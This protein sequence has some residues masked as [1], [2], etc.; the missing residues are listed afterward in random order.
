MTRWSLGVDL[1]TSFSSAA[2]ATA[3]QV[4]SLEVSGERRIPSTIVLDESGALVAGTLAQRMV[5][6]GPER[7]ERNP[8]RYVGRRPMLLGG[9]PVTAQRALA[10]L[11]ELVVGEART[12]FDGSAPASLVLTHPVA[13]SPAQRQ[14]LLEVA[15]VVLPGRPVE[16]VEE[17][18][19]AAVHYSHTHA[20]DGIGGRDSVAVYDLGGGTF[21]TAVLTAEGSGFSVVGSPGGDPE[22]GGETFD[23]RVFHHFGAQLGRLAPEWWE[24]VSSNP[25]RRWQAAAA[26]LLTEARLAKESLS[27]HEDAVQYVPGADTDVRITRAEFDAL[28]GEDVRRTTRL[29]AQSI[30]GSGRDPRDLRGIF[31]TGGASRIPLVRDALRAQYDGLVRTAPDP[32]TVVALGAARWAQRTL[33]ARPVTAPRR[34]GASALPVLATDVLDAQAANGAIYTWGVG[35]GGHQ[36]R[37][38]DRGGR[39]ERELPM[40]LV[41]GWAI[42]DDLVLVAERR[43]QVVRVHAL[44][45][46]LIIRSTTDLVTAHDPWLLAQG[47]HGWVFLRGPSTGPVDNTVGLPWGETG[48]LQVVVIRPAAS[49]TPVNAVPRPLGSTATWFV[50]EDGVR[51]RLLDQA[52]PT[53][54]PPTALGDGRTAAVVLGKITRRRTGLRT[55]TIVPSQVIGTVD[56]EG[57]LTVIAEQQDTTGLW[58]HQALE[59]DGWFLSTNSGLETFAGP[60]RSLF[61]ERPRA[62]AARWVAT[63]NR[64]YGVVQDSLVPNRGLALHMYDERAPRGLG[65]YPGLLGNLASVDRAEAPRLRVDGDL[66]WVGTRMSEGISQVLVVNGARVEQVAAAEGWLEPVGQGFALHAPD[67]APGDSRT[68]PAT[69]VRLPG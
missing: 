19:A 3:T 29:L 52:M 37:K 58:V 25:D 68:G 23:E 46:E 9:E 27:E 32:K 14:V 17:P 18:V 35:A 45:P 53:S 56:A 20:A 47:G 61:V 44:S 2:I 60:D 42:A 16:L 67:T 22:I 7:G 51:R 5:G 55:S 6:R 38:L 26:A 36:I 49:F 15:E 66:L 50:N 65:T 39:V 4:E 33:T 43:E 64:V 21:D 59:R 24:Q 10:A 34:P 63:A 11:L 12:R 31:L 30:E 54:V 40:S 28:V 41:T 62:G 13:W 48:D 57:Q 8:R 69:L 1:G